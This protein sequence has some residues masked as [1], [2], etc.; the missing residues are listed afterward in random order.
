MGRAPA[1]QAV[2]LLAGLCSSCPCWVTAVAPGATASV[3]DD[4]TLAGGGGKGRRGA[5]RGGGD[6]EEPRRRGRT[7]ESLYITYLND[8]FKYCIPVHTCNEMQCSRLVTMKAQYIPRHDQAVAMTLKT[9]KNEIR[10]D[11]TPSWM[12]GRLRTCL[13]A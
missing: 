12:L 10:A 6:V 9:Q 13:K 1:G 2:L 11:A 8:I 4:G 7:P 3:S 5:G